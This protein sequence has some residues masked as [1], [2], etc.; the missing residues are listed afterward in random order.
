MASSNIVQQLRNQAGLSREMLASKA[1][2][3]LSLLTKYERGEVRRPSLISVRRLAKILS[4]R[5]GVTEESLLLQIAEGLEC[6][7]NRDP[8]K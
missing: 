7:P 2:V 8:S 5:L 6:P 3:T 1:G 4:Q